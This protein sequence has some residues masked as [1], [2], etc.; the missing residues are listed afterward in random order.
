MPP[1]RGVVRVRPTERRRAGVWH[2]KEAWQRGRQPGE[3]VFASG[4]RRSVGRRGCEL[5]RQ[6][7]HPAPATPPHGVVAFPVQLLSLSAS[8]FYSRLSPSPSVSL[9]RRDAVSH[10]L[11]LALACLTCAVF[12]GDQQF[13]QHV[14]VPPQD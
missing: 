3:P 1:A 2:R 7:L 14:Q 5:P 13:A 9:E 10:L 6:G 8:Y 12:L 11:P 4:A